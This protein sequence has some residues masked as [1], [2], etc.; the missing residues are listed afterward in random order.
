MQAPNPQETNQK[1]N[2]WRWKF[3]NAP[4][5]VIKVNSVDDNSCPQLQLSGRLPEEYIQCFVLVFGE[6]IIS[7]V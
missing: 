3:H 7:I 6:T 2:I 1:G 4:V 5:S